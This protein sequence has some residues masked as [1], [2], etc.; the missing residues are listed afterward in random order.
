[1]MCTTELHGGVYHRTSTL[2]KRGNKMK[3]KKK[4]LVQS[5]VPYPRLSISTYPQQELLAL[6]TLTPERGAPTIEPLC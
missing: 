4:T 5:R 2:P 3:E 1:M 6:R